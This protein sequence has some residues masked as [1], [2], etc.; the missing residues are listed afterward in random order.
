MGKEEIKIRLFTNDTISIQ[1]RWQTA[2]WLLVHRSY[3][4]KA[5]A[6]SPWPTVELQGEPC[7]LKGCGNVS[8]GQLVSLIFPKDP[9]GSFES[10]RVPK[11]TRRASGRH[12]S[13]TILGQS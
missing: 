4:V 9:R 11:L 1:R 10:T 5:D 8:Q 12:W 6:S 13:C 3:R 2:L 7:S